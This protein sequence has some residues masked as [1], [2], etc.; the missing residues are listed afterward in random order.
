MTLSDELHEPRTSPF[1]PSHGRHQWDVNDNTLPPVSDFDQFEEWP[2]GHSRYVYPADMEDARRHSSGWAMRNTNNHNVNILKKSCLGVLVCSQ[3]CVLENQTKVHMR[4]AI[5]DKARKKQ[6]NK[7]CPNQRCNGRLELMACRGHCGYPV[8]H[9]WRQSNG[10]IFFQAKGIHDHPQPE[11]KSSAEGYRRFAS[12]K[13]RP[14]SAVTTTSSPPGFNQFKIPRIEM[15]STT[16]PSPCPF[17]AFE[18]AAHHNST[19]RLFYETHYTPAAEFESSNHNY[20]TLRQYQNPPSDFDFLPQEQ[21]CPPTFAPPPPP[22][23]THAHP[24]APVPQVSECLYTP[25][26]T[27]S[28]ADSCTFNDPSEFLQFSSKKTDDLP[29]F[30]PA[31]MQEA[32]KNSSYAELQPVQGSRTA[33]F[34]PEQNTVSTGYDFFPTYSSLRYASTG[35]VTEYNPFLPSFGYTTQ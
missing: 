2:N 20:P 1:A 26:S 24:S 30:G 18:T 22:H 33:S 10:A 25:A 4:P 5:C 17:P 23:H 12:P 28:T 13:K 16:A 19:P 14:A 32:A 27:I 21:Y 3:R 8:T 6:I 7:A 35:E 11:A 15:S 29:S 31:F 34:F 9:F